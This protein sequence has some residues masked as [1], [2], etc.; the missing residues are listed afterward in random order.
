M[1]CLKRL[2][3]CQLLQLKLIVQTG[4]ESPGRRCKQILKHPACLV[5]SIMTGRAQ[6][7]K[8]TTCLSN[9]WSNV[10]NLYIT[11]WNFHISG[12]Q[13]FNCGCI[14]KQQV[15][16]LSAT[17]YYTRIVKPFVWLYCLTQAS[18]FQVS[19]S[20]TAGMLAGCWYA[21]IYIL[22]SCNGMSNRR[23]D[24]MFPSPAVDLVCVCGA[25]AWKSYSHILQ[26][27][28]QNVSQISKI[29]QIWKLWSSQL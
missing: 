24:M 25:C 17:Y 16:I 5:T 12:S 10:C 8:W 3:F 26:N 7:L 21:T 6:G 4:D 11:R 1:V 29:S 28:I 13:Q 20:A 14:Q 19:L 15:L 22:F 27:N 2:Y 23:T 9:T 18:Y